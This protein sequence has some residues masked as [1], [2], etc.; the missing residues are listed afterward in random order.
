[1]T[2]YDNP[3]PYAEATPE[4]G[5]RAEPALRPAGNGVRWL[6][7]A[8]ELFL[9]APFTLVIMFV[10]YMVISILAGFIPL[11]GDV[12]MALTWGFWGAGFALAADK[13][14]RG[15][16]IMV[17]EL[18]AGFSHRNARSLFFVGLIYLGLFVAFAV[19]VVVLAV[20]AFG[21]G[22]LA[23]YSEVNAFVERLAANIGIFLAL[24]VVLLTGVFLIL[25]YVLYAPLLVVLHDLPV[26]QACALSLRAILRNW[27]SMTVCGLVLL[28]LAIASVI[29][30]FLGLLVLFPL[31]FVTVY[32]SYRDIF[33]EDPWQ[34][35]E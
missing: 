16:E 19:L 32:T 26:Q 11:L 27:V 24:M 18:F 29:T 28:G 21:A 23:E 20:F 33:L 35:S 34:G 9:K 1:M 4:P 15:G 7:Q 5:L 31:M 3:D 12:A 14:Q 25:A 10:L 2:D 17:G 6:E 30:L 8:W 13:L 22:N